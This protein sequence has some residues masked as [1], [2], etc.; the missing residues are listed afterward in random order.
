MGKYVTIDE[1]IQ[2]QEP[3][4]REILITLRTYV[5]K[6][7]P[8]AKEAIK[9]S[10]PVYEDENGP[11][12]FIRAYKEHINIGFWRGAIMKDPAGILE[13]DGEKMRHIKIV[14]ISRI[15]ETLIAE[16]VKQ[17][18]ALNDELGNPTR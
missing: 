7:A 14:N 13:G 3:W 9:W 10:Q 4:K 5:K 15:D 8:N 11:F 18:V 2:N 6:Y 1:Y 12:C 17:A 16:F